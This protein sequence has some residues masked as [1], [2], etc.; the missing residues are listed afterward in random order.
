MLT[1]VED[2]AAEVR[3]AA[4]RALGRRLAELPLAERDVTLLGMLAADEERSVRTQVALS[5]EQVG[6]ADAARRL[7]ELLEAEEELRLRWRIVAGLQR[8]SG[9]RFRLD[10]RPWKDWAAALPDDFEPGTAEASSPVAEREQSEAEFASLPLRSSRIAFLFDFSGSIYKR[11]A[12]GTTYMEW[13][14][15]ELEKA[16]GQLDESVL[17]NVIP[18][19]LMPIPW[20]D[21]LQPAK[22]RNVAKA[23]EYL[24]SRWDQGKGNFWSAA[25]LAL[26]DPELD[27]ILLFSDGKPTGGSHWEM[28]LTVDLLLE[29]N[30]FQHVTYDAIL[31]EIGGGYL[32]NQW[33][34]LARESGGWVVE[35]EE[36][37]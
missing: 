11:R 28:G 37:R 4:A 12:D 36:G 25:E 5:L 9:K 26:V 15:A 1:G 3:C 13:L 30:R 32:R 22:K 8:L 21:E 33:E 19:T 34:R 6:T 17:F 14:Q 20:E 2:K 29:R 16:L 35:L 24:E 18:Y 10:P 23:L 27:S 31:V 7:G